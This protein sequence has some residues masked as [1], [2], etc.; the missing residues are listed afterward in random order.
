MGESKTN[1]FMTGRQSPPLEEIK[2]EVEDY[3][4]V[5]AMISHK[6]ESRNM[7]AT[8]GFNSETK[9]FAKK[10]GGLTT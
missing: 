7:A 2:Q 4:D 6:E 9:N 5:V 3:D 8:P 1:N 10:R